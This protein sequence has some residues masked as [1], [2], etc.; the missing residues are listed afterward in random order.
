MYQIIKSLLFAA[1]GTAP[2]I[3]MSVQMEK[4]FPGAVVAALG[5]FVGFGLSL[6]STSLSRVLRGTA[7]SIVAYNVPRFLRGGTMD[8]FLQ[9][10]N[11]PE[12]PREFP[13]ES[14]RIGY[15]DLTQADAGMLTIT[16]AAANKL[17]EHR[18]TGMA[19]APVRIICTIN[20][21]IGYYLVHNMEFESEWNSQRDLY[22]ESQGIGF[23]T[24]R[25][26]AKRL[27]GTTLD[28]EVSDAGQGFSFNSPHWPRRTLD[29]E[30]WETTTKPETVASASSPWGKLAV[31][32]GAF[33]VAIVIKF[34]LFSAKRADQN[35]QPAI[36]EQ[37]RAAATQQQSEQLKKAIERDDQLSEALLILSGTDVKEFRKQQ[38]KI[39]DQ[40][41]EAGDESQPKAMPDADLR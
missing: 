10:K 4:L 40:K 15:R 2:G 5:C 22:G 6:R 25:L 8:A 27:Q 34:A 24:D 26:S 17:R 38:Q 7:G 12:N 31:G 13:N 16:E 20:P 30:P 35:P 37:A 32:L 3:F 28:W 21:Q 36:P 18:P 41:A 33:V 11:Q 29:H 23:V 1:I 39:R 19:D 9:E 14:D